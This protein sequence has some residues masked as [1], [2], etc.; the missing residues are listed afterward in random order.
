[1]PYQGNNLTT[2]SHKLYVARGLAGA[3]TPI[4]LTTEGDFAQM[5]SDVLDILRD[6][7]IT[8]KDAPVFAETPANGLLFSIAATAAADKDLNWR[9]LAWRNENGPAEIVAN[10]T[11]RTGSQAVVVYPHG[12]A[13]A[14][15]YWCDT[16]VITAEYWPKEIEATAAGGDSVSKLFLDAC[17]YRY[18]KMEIT[19]PGAGNDITLAAVF[20]GYF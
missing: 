3:D 10:G 13:T 1:M 17:G 2:L 7:I 12:V 16:I 15:A 19:L 18:F 6:D 4:D 9:L 5:P 11:A 20:Y 8:P 14:T